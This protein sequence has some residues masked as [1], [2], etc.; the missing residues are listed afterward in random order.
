LTKTLAFIALALP[1]A[2]GWQAAAQTWDNTGNNLLNGTYYFRQVLWWGRADSA[3]D[4]TEGTAAYGTITFNGNG[5]YS[6]SATGVQVFDKNVESGASLGALGPVSGTYT[7]AASGYGFISSPLV[8]GDPIN[9]L[10]SPTGIVVGSTTDHNSVYNDLFVAAP[11]P[12]SAPS[13]AGT[14]SLIGVDIPALTL[15]VADTRSYS[16]NMTASGSG[17]ITTTMPAGEIA[18]GQQPTQSAFSGASYSIANDVAVVM[19]G[20]EL[21]S[22]TL[23]TDLMSGTKYFYFSPD[24]NFIFGGDPED[25]DFIV[26]VRQNTN[27]SLTYT[28]LYYTAS[29]SQDD[30]QFNSCSCAYLD[31][32]YGA[33]DSLSTG[34]GLGH[35]RDLDV[36]PPSVG[37]SVYDHTFSSSLCCLGSIDITDSAVDGYNEYFFG[38]GGAIAI[39]LPLGLGTLGIEVL[40]Q[41]PTFSAPGGAPYIFPTGVV[42][43]GSSVPFTAGWA[44]G[45]VISIYGQNFTTANITESSGNFPTMMGGLQVLINGTPA[46]LYSVNHSSSYDQI[47]A[48]A[49]MSLTPNTIASI[50][51]VNGG[52]SSNIVTNYINHTQIGIFGSYTSAPAIEH[53][54][55]TLVTFDNPAQPGEELAVYLTGLGAL[56][57]QGNSTDTKIAVEVDGVAACPSSMPF[58]PC[59]GIEYSGIEPG[60]PIAV[61]GGYQLNFRV[62]ESLGSEL[63]LYGVSWPF[64]WPLEA[65]IRTTRKR[66]YT[67]APTSTMTLPYRRREL[68][69]PS[70]TRP[71]QTPAIRNHPGCAPSTSRTHGPSKPLPDGVPGGPG[72]ESTLC[73]AFR[74]STSRS[75]GTAPRASRA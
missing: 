73:D 2:A 40:A 62:P 39:G 70:P 50:Q 29:L 32:T 72:S 44:P 25:F 71:A 51:V 30:S 60:N 1:I 9:V 26:G 7:I 10:V 31:S 5:S 21:G 42:N 12:T 46:P 33:W 65:R 74:A 58:Y 34:Q 59:S 41:A 57:A 18:T 23:H 35:Q 68:V 75:A 67:S 13:L 28:G 49:P 20:P 63:G 16:F 14:Y 56:N 66:R 15:G 19:F 55:S 53:G 38:S 36:G 69:R 22:T 27:A 61:G 3:N 6:I 8:I 43:A 47:N 37:H 52:G 48:V 4:L 45:E 11:V 24:G 17:G 64:T 54:N